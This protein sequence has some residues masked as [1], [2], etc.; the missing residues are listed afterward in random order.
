METIFIPAFILGMLSNLH[1]L[2]M[3]GPI[4]LAIPLN[5]TSKS[6]MLFGI[7]QYHIGRILVYGILGYLVGY[8][9]MGIKLFGVLQAISIIAGIG[10]IIYAWRK[11]IN[12]TKIKLPSF[13]G[14]LSLSKGHSSLLS[15]YMGKIMRS[16]SP[17][18]LFLLGALNGLLPC[19][20]V[21]TALI[22]AVVLGT[23]LLSATSMLA[24]GLGTLPGLVAF[25]LFAQQLGNPIRSKINRYLPY[26][27]TLVG[28]LIILRGMNLNIPYISPKVSVVESS[29]PSKNKKVVMDCCHKS[30]KCEKK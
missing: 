5:R 25:S 21:Y 6:A 13:L 15:S 23:P 18:K 4:A 16:K 30:T 9:G 3:C 19:G 17:L 11:K 1:C 14:P 22:T 20:M 8:I 10:I 12:F 27:I 2:G 24:F 28:L 7:L 26:L 29:T